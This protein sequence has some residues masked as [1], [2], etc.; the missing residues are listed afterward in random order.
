MHAR[1]DTLLSL[2][3]CFYKPS[4]GEIR[5]DGVPVSEYDLSTLR[6]RIGYVS[7][8]AELLTGTIMENLC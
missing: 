5:F 1:V 6:K 3:L 8:D 4:E 7:Q 2:I